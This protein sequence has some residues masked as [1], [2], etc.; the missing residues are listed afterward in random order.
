M[1]MLPEG[2]NAAESV[3]NLW[4]P[5]WQKRRSS[6]DLWLAS[7]MSCRSGLCEKTAQ[8]GR[9]AISQANVDVRLFVPGGV[10][11]RLFWTGKS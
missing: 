9:L 4:A 5:P 11:L 7:F 1:P 2:R 8:P 6:W 3:R 10:G